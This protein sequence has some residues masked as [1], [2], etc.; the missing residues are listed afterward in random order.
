[1]TWFQ[2]EARSVMSGHSAWRPS[3]ANTHPVRTWGEPRRVGERNGPR[4]P[5]ALPSKKEKALRYAAVGYDTRM[6]EPLLDRLL[7]CG[8]AGLCILLCWTI[9]SSIHVTIIEP[10]DRAPTFEIATNNGGKVSNTNFGGKALLLNFWATWCATCMEE[11]PSLDRMAQIMRPKGL[12]VVALSVDK[13]RDR[14]TR[15]LQ[16]AQPQFLTGIDPIAEIPTRFGSFQWPETYIIDKRGVVRN[17][18]ISNQNWTSPV[19]LAQLESIL[20]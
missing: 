1:M 6:R 14:Y 17:K 10:G 19:I 9:Y 16:L 12:V 11:M 20:D 4:A 2:V 8:I 18:F 3:A 13:E 7:K 15:F 5:R